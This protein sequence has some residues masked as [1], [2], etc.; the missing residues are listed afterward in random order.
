MSRK[1]KKCDSVSG[2]SDAFDEI[3]P[4]CSQCALSLVFLVPCECFVANE[5]SYLLLFISTPSTE[6]M[7]VVT[8]TPGKTINIGHNP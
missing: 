2:P 5:T 4:P 8:V 3:E 6:V 7:S 1:Q